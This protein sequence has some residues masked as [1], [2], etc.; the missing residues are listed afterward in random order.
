MPVTR[1]AMWSGPRNIST[2]LMRSFE[3]RPDCAVVDEPL[4][5]YYLKT[6][7]YN[8]PGGEDIVAAM[9]CNWQSVT[10]ALCNVKPELCGVFYQ[11]HMTQHLL[12]EVK[13]DFVDDLENCFL[14][15]E[16]RRIIASYR[17]IRSDFTLEELGFPQQWEL[18]KRVADLRGHAPPV[19][20]SAQLL[21]N[22]E[23]NL[24]ALCE[25]VGVGFSECML[26]W[27]RGR[28]NSD[29]VWAPHWYASVE[30][31]TGFQAQEEQPLKMVN[32]PAQYEDMCERANCI[33]AALYEHALGANV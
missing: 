28:R 24:R 5:G 23:A 14:I 13:L 8:H 12:P 1:I 32:I 2:A 31:S 22:P 3:N 18:F 25:R 21:R 33:Y 10:H 4:Y 30:E 6:T 26:R 15:R 11:K 20:D 16:P 29:G 9:D 19:I 7:G 17:N 27:P